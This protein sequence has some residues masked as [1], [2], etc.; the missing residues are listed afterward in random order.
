MPQ[1]P[2]VVST[3]GSSPA[4]ARG[5]TLGMGLPSDATSP[6][7]SSSHRAATFGGTKN[8]RFMSGAVDAAQ[9][10]SS[11][12]KA[13]FKRNYLTESN[14]HRG[15]RLLTHHVSSENGAVCTCT[16]MDQ[17]WLIIGMANGRIHVFDARTGLYERTLGGGGND[18]GVWCLALVSKTKGVRRSKKGKGKGKATSTTPTHKYF[19]QPADGNRH[20]QMEYVTAEHQI[21]LVDYDP[22]LA[23][24]I[25]SKTANTEASKAG[26]AAGSPWFPMTRRAIQ[27]GVGS[28]RRA[29]SSLRGGEAPTT[30]ITG[31]TTTTTATTTNSAGEAG[32]GP[33][34]IGGYPRDVVEAGPE[35]IRESILSSASREGLSAED[36]A[37]QQG[38]AQEVFDTLTRIRAE[39]GITGRRT[40]PR[41]SRTQPHEEGGDEAMDEEQDAGASGSASGAADAADVVMDDVQDEVQFEE[42][43]ADLDLDEEYNDVESDDSDEDDDSYEGFSMGIGGS[44]NGLGTLCGATHGYGNESAILVSGG[45]DREVKVWDVSTGELKHTMRGHASTVRC[46]RV[47]EGRPIAVSG[48]R[49]STV[50]VWDLETGQLLRI[51]AGHQNSVRCLEVAGNQVATGSYDCTCRIWDVDTGECLHVLRGHYNQIYCVAFD[52]NKVATGSLDSTVRIWSSSTGEPLALLQGHTALV[53]TL[54]LSKN[55]LISG[56][57]DGRILVYSLYDMTLL[58]AICAHDNSVSCFQFDEH[59]IVTGGNDGAVRLWNLYDGSFIRELTRPMNSVWKL[60][61]RDDKVLAMCKRADESLSMEVIDFRPVE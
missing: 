20:G 19:T 16:A 51:L 50:R 42:N 27:R 33:E 52:G 29:A 49:D 31:T 8:Q 41:P 32:A 4:H 53:G 59:F 26:S 43:A 14:W 21:R 44:A 18:S 11:S 60:A 3:R 34:L 2:P 45:C 48:G 37:R 46:L 47:L 30:P 35:F 36:R 28:A 10:P 9:D 61:F 57:S 13:H 39:H 38:T 24:A 23:G 40:I 54:Q 25:E 6:G 58:Y 15:G 22:R 5:S 1:A 55:I 17:R 7:A 56:G 12:A